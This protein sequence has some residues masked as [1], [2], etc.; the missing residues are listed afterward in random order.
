MPLQGCSIDFVEVEVDVET[1][2]ITTINY[3][4]AVDPGRAINPDGVEG[5]FQHALS[6]G[7]GWSLMEKLVVDKTTGRPLNANYLDYKIPTTLDI[8]ESSSIVMVEPIDPV[9]PFGAKGAGE[10]AIA[11]SAGAFVNAIHVAIGVKFNDFPITPDKI[12]KALGKG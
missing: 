5:Q 2:E 7:M 9:G 10:E 12:L 8:A 6:A 11:S 3:V 4:V 1:G